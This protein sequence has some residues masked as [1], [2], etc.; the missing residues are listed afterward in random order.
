MRRVVQS[1]ED[2]AAPRASTAIDGASTTYEPLGGGASH[3]PCTPV[4]A[5]E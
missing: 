1:I 3:R 4:V 2:A 5:P